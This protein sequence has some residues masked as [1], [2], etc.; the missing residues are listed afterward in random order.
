MHLLACFPLVPSGDNDRQN[1]KKILPQ[2]LGGTGCVE[3]TGER[4]LE[5]DKRN[6]TEY[7]P[8][9]WW[10]AVPQSLTMGTRGSC[11]SGVPR[12]T[13]I[14]FKLL[15]HICCVTLGTSLPFSELSCTQE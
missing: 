7:E 8:T 15:I 12:L 10:G 3:R 1:F 14:G 2:V 9:P 13:D 5:K 11:G 4:Y 6:C